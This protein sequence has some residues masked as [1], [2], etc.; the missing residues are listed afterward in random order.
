MLRLHV[1]TRLRP[2]RYRYRIPVS[3]AVTVSGTVKVLNGTRY[4][5]PDVGIGYWMSVLVSD[6]V[7]RYRHPLTASVGCRYRI[8]ISEPIPI[9]TSSLTSH[10][11]VIAFNPKFFNPKFSIL[12]CLILS[13]LDDDDDDASFA[14][15]STTRSFSSP[16]SLTRTSGVLPRFCTSGGRRI[17]N[18]AALPLPAFFRCSALHTFG[19]LPNGS[20]INLVLPNDI[21]LVLPLFRR[22]RAEF[23]FLLSLSL[24]FSL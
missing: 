16:S 11:C 17:G 6:I 19:F 4:R 7:I 15:F 23:F 14:N 10:F 8:S 12:I 22:E 13:T 2:F 1:I 20:G 9:P 5:H 3:I 24:S 21:L 18:S